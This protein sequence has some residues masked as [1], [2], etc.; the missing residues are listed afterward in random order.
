MNQ[1]LEELERL[2]KQEMGLLAQLPAPDP[3]ADAVGR[4]QDAVRA[5][6]ARLRP[7]RERVWVLPRWA[8]VAAAALLAV[9]LSDVFRGSLS[10]TGNTGDTRNALDVWAEAIQDSSDRMAYLLDYGWLVDSGTSEGSEPL[11]GLLESL[12]TSF[13]EL[14]T[15]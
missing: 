13:K 7:P 2:V 9:G 4:V 5:E 8:A 1:K 11:Q 12:D 3:G 6:A 14:G 10:P 15:L